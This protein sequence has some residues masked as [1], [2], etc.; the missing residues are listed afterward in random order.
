MIM[1]F[2]LGWF[3]KLTSW[4][5][6]LF[7]FK[8]KVHYEDKSVQSKRVRGKA[9]IASNHRSV[10]DFGIMM[11]VFFGR[12]LRCVVAEVI[13]ARN[14]ILKLFLM[15]LGAIRVDRSSHDFSFIGKC[16]RVLDRGGV[17]EI[18]PESRL[19]R[20]GEQTPL[21]FKPST[22]YLALESGAPIIP[23]YH[24]GKHFSKERTRVIIGKP[25][26][27]RELYDQA[28]SEKENIQ[29]ITNYLR[30]RIIELGK[31]L[32]RQEKEEGRPDQRS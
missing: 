11:F 20:A 9:I 28:L 14:F 16:K 22:V 17:V 30:G 8:I 15:G 25:I 32:E 4:L 29:S 2:L 3:V 18:Y 27:A 19:P 26:Y 1:A 6:Q 21:E 5:P 12:T 10:W 7:V 13:F 24:N 31:E 23:V